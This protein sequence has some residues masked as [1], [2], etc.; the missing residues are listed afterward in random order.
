MWHEADGRPDAGEAKNL[1]GALWLS[2]VVK[3]GLL[4]KASRARSG[5]TI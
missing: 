4:C 3:R 2:D 5:P 1:L